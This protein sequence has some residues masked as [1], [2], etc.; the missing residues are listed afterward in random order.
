MGKGWVSLD[1]RNEG[2][3]TTGKGKKKEKPVPAPGDDDNSSKAPD[4]PAG[5]G[6]IDGSFVAYRIRT[7][8]TKKSRTKTSRK[9]KIDIE[10]DEDGDSIIDVDTDAHVDSAADPGWDVILPTFEEEDREDKDA[11]DMIEKGI[12]GR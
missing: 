8:P 11:D 3:I 4:T 10:D 5:A 12:N 9:A 1:S 7:S 6:L 2:S